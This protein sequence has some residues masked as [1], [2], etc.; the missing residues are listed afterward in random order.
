MVSSVRDLGAENRSHTLILT[1][2]D[3]ANRIGKLFRESID[4][5]WPSGVVSFLLNKGFLRGKEKLEPSLELFPASNIIWRDSGSQAA[6]L[7]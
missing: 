5:P 2:P 4:F 1:P 3:E 6:A 7:R